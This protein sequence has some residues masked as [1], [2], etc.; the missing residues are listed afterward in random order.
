MRS[1]RIGPGPKVNDVG[2]GRRRRI[3]RLLQIRKRTR[4][5]GRKATA[6][7][8]CHIRR[9]RRRPVSYGNEARG[10]RSDHVAARTEG[11]DHGLIPLNEM[12]NLRVN[13]HRDIALSRRHG[14]ASRQQIVVHAVRGRAAQRV[15]DREWRICRIRRSCEPEGAAHRPDLGRVRGGH[16][17]PDIEKTDRLGDR[18]PRLFARRIRRIVAVIEHPVTI[19]ERHIRCEWPNP[20]HAK[21]IGVHPDRL[22]VGAVN[23]PPIQVYVGTTIAVRTQITVE[24]A[25]A[26]NHVRCR[27]IRDC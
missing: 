27:K 14:N 4:P 2:A 26:G 8:G 7:A 19:V 3:Q 13:G 17:D 15:V 10:R 25:A 23:R 12:I 9:G 11:K 20:A 22:V 6:A 24:I 16:F 21:I 5:V 18:R 1:D